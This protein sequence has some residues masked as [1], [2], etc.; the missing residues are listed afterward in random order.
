MEHFPEFIANHLFL[1]SLLVALLVLLAWNL[2]GYSI[3][4]VNMVIPME[5][6]S[7]INH[8]NA[9]VIDVRSETDFKTGYILNALNFPATDMEKRQDDLKKYSKRTVILYCNNG[10]ESARLCRM[11]K[12]QGF[13]KLNCLK[14]GVYAWRNANLPLSR[15][16][17]DETA[18]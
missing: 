12:Q 2:F 16:E 17:S 13:D 15:V 7:L 1:F 5:A 9:V 6:T 18:S 8:E 10:S 4:G 14:G 11:L 3:T